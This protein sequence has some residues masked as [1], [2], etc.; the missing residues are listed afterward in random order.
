MN[1]VEQL[2]IQP[3]VK[4]LAEEKIIYK[5]F[6]FFGLINVKGEPF[7][8]EY[9]CRMGDPETE[10]VMPR[11]KNDLVELFI[12]AHEGKLSEAKVE[13]DKRACATVV[14]VSGGYPGDYKK[15]L[16]ISGFENLK[17]NDDSIIF[18]AGTKKVNDT[19]VTNGGR[20]LAVT[21]Y[22]NDITDAV[23]KSKKV[24]EQ[25]HFEGMYYRRD[26]GYE[27]V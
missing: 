7:V 24:L 1:K 16:K 6:I 2:I 17:M 26:I 20:V 19:I 25:I 15:N 27:F 10:V 23:N 21:S 13:F 14:A 8:I 11:L 12:A 4:G 3:T 22:G 18:H 5:G 9:N